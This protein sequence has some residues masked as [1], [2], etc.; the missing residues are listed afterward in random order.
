MIDRCWVGV[1]HCL[2]KGHA[3][4]DRNRCQVHTVGH[5]A[6]RI[7]RWNTGLAIL[8]HNDFATTAQHAASFFNTQT[9]RV[10]FTARCEQNLIENGFDASGRLNPNP[11]VTFFHLSD[12]RAQL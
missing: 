9:M 6:N 7:D 8:I 5:I 2:N 3:F 4:A 1:E 11:A 12:V 10:W